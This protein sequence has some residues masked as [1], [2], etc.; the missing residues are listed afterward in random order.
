MKMEESMD[1]V[2]TQAVEDDSQLN[3]VDLLKKYKIDY[4][5][6]K[7]LW[8][9][10][11]YDSYREP[12]RSARKKSGGFEKPVAAAAS[13][14]P[15]VGAESEERDSG[16]FAAEREGINNGVVGGIFM[17]VI[18]LLWFF[19]GR[20]AGYIFFYPPILGIIGV[21][22]VLKGIFTGNVS[23]KRC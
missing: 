21:Y 2:M 1:A 22:A 7:Y 14:Q 3:I 18:A 16:F 12:L 8:G 17:I 10:E 13:E 6:G 5:N 11:V 4:V 20:A 19:I 15:S 9:G 23:G